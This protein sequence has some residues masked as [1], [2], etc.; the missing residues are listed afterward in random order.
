MVKNAW[1]IFNPVAGRSSGEADLAL[2]E[3]RLKPSLD[4]HICQTSPECDADSLARDALAAGAELIIASGGDGTLSAVAEVLINRSIPL[5]IIPRG[6]ANA[7]AT[8][9]GVPTD[10][11]QACQVILDGHVRRIDTAQCNGRPMLLLAGIGFEALTIEQTTRERKSRLGILAYVLTG[12]QHLSEL[13]VFELTVETEN[14]RIVCQAAAVTVANVAPPTSILAQG[15]ATLRADD[16]LLDITIVAARSLLE[17]VATGYHLFS[18]ALQHLPVSRD[19]IGYFRCSHLRITTN[20]PQKVV[21]DGE[22]A[23]TTPLE[24]K[25]LPQSLPVLVPQAVPE[26]VAPREKLEGLPNLTVETKTSSTLQ[27]ETKTEPLVNS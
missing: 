23:G 7:L 2:I 24:V 21:I 12:L 10:I 8:D 5:G 17:A 26:A 6:T 13:A 3:Q 25:C 14:Q 20:P 27:V 22:V 9:L 1:L 4:L 18:T 19:N 16:G 15:P 11:E